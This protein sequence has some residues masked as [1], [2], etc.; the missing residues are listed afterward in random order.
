MF[1][2]IMLL[3]LII[4]VVVEDI[5]LKLDNK[6]PRLELVLIVCSM[7]YAWYFLRLIWSVKV[8]EF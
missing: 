7:H 4:F 1:I 8:V 2:N 5:R 3:I 6:L